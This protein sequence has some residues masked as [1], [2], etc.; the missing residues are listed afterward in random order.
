MTF[1]WQRPLTVYLA[2]PMT[3]FDRAHMV[4]LS[5]Q[6]LELA[7]KYGIKAWSPVLI[8]KVPDKRGRLFNN[9]NSLN[10]KW[11]LDMH[12][13]NNSFAFINLRA[14]EKSFG[15][16]DEYGRHRYSEWQ[17]VVRVSPKHAAGYKSIANYQT[18]IVVGTVEEA[19][20]EL[21]ARFGTWQQRFTWKV[22]L[23]VK[24]GPRWLGR[25]I[26]RLFQ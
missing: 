17:P 3:G 8:E 16:E 23:L 20:Q 1:F 14:D 9:D 12:A 11:P 18:D 22:A 2:I 25:Q 5:R 7:E 4:E 19:M 13:M 6:A 15:C 26:K 24:S 10:W 21:S